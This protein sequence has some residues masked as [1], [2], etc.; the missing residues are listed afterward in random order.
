[1]LRRDRL[2]FLAP[3][4]LQT[5]A[6]DIDNRRALFDHLVKFRTCCNGFIADKPM[7]RVTQHL[8]I[9]FGAELDLIQNEQ[10]IFRV[11][12]RRARA[13]FVRI[14]LVPRHD[15]GI[16]GQHA[17]QFLCQ[18]ISDISL[19]VSILSKLYPLADIIDLTDLSFG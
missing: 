8:D 9:K 4:A 13:H 19:R 5:S 11:T 2:S 15:L 17:A 18:F 12:D 10:F 7:L 3:R 14:H 6:P 1:M 16:F